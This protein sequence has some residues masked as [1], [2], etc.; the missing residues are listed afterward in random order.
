LDKQL[1]IALAGRLYWEKKSHILYTCGNSY[2]I[3]ENF[4][5]SR[6]AALEKVAKQKLR[7]RIAK[8]VFFKDPKNIISVEWSLS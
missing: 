7:M 2:S 3:Y 4:L 1:A 6:R 8:P 5:F